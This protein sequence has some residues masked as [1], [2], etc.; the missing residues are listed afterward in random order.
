MVL[1]P[2]RLRQKQLKSEL[3]TGVQAPV[4]S[5]PK[6]GRKRGGKRA[7][8]TLKQTRHTRLLMEGVALVLAMGGMFAGYLAWRLS[9]GTVSIV[10]ATPLVED[11]L[12]RLVGGPTKIGT[13]RLGWDPVERD[14]VV[15]AG[16]ITAR[17]DKRTSPLRL[18]QV[19]MALDAPSLLA[20]RAVVKQARLS[21]VEAVLVI[22]QQGRTAFGF[23]TAQQVLALPRVLGQ[24]GALAHMI[25]ATRKA[26]DPTG[27]AGRVAQVVLRNAQLQVIDPDSGERL[28][29]QGAQAGLYRNEVGIITFHASG[30]VSNSPSSINIALAAP[31]DP[32]GTLSVIANVNQIR[33]AQIP[34]SLRQGQMEK[35]VSW[36]SPLGGRALG[37]LTPN[38]KVIDVAGRIEVGAGQ[39]AGFV[40]DRAKGQFSWQ[41][42]SGIIRLENAS[43]SGNHIRGEGLQAIVFPLDSASRRIDL[44]AKSFAIEDMTLGGLMGTQVKGRLN[45]SSQSRLQTAQLSAKSLGVSATDT[46]TLTLLDARLTLSSEGAYGQNERSTVDGL[47]AGG[48]VKGNVRAAGVALADRGGSLGSG[49][50]VALDFGKQGAG[51]GWQGSASL[52]NLNLVGRGASWPQT[53]VRGLSVRLDGLGIPSQT[54]FNLDVES[55]RTRQIVGRGL[56][57]SGSN[58]RVAVRSSRAGAWALENFSADA[59]GV[60]TPILG[61]VSGPLRASGTFSKLG[62]QDAEIQTSILSL[63]NPAQVPRP[64][65][66]TDV[67]FDGDIL[68]RKVTFREAQFRHRGIDVEGSGEVALAPRGS[69]KVYLDA[70]IDGEINVETLLSAWPRGF[71][72]ETR[73][74]IAQ[75]VR[76]GIATTDKLT[77]RVPPGL[78]HGQMGGPDMIA[79]DFDVREGTVQYLPGMTALTNVSG[80]ARLRGNSFRVDV[81]RGN[82]DGLVLNQGY[83]AIPQ[84]APKEALAVV[85]ATVTG[86]VARMASEADR[87]PLR[88]FSNVQFDP[89]RLAGEGSLDLDL[90]LPLSDRLKPDEV[91]VRARGHFEQASLKDAFAGLEA[92]DGAVDLD[93]AGQRVTVAGKARLAGNTFDFVWKN[94]IEPSNEKANLQEGSQLLA[95]GL[96]DLA[97]LNQM[98][99]DVS[100]YATGPVQLSVDVQSQSSK[101]V[102]A[103]VLADVQPASIQLQGSSWSKPAGEPG[104]AKARIVGQPG[105]GWQ[106]NGLEFETKGASIRGQMALSDQLDLKVADFPQIRIE[107]VADI[108]FKLSQEKGALDLAVI[109]EYLDLN[110]FR[111]RVDVTE[112]AANLL[113]QPMR[114]TAQIKR[115]ATGPI[116]SLADMEAT[117][118]RDEAGWRSMRIT[119]QAEAGPTEIEMKPQADGRR[120]IVGTLSDVGFF[121]RLMYPAAPLSGGTGV[122][123]GELPIVGAKS[124]GN[125]SLEVKNISFLQGNQIPIAFDLVRLPMSVSGGLLS[126][127]DGKADG[128]AYTVKA[129]GYVDFE[130]GQ[131]DLRGVATPGG[132]NRVLGEVPL[133]GGLLGG[134]K[135]EGLVGLTFSA[136]GSLANPK[137]RTNPISA[138]APG[139]LRKLFETQAPNEPPKA[140]QTP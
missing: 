39:V 11:A 80:R 12:A 128:A 96:V 117:I 32:Q 98:G 1:I 30:K 44:D 113:K 105:L 108:G 132:L 18:G 133:I 62:L 135:D 90:S 27:Q 34:R 104:S 7:K 88:I 106:V 120:T 78:L 85:Q 9:I 52:A 131:M 19:D 25:Q 87:E 89:A 121:A 118:V 68:S 47:L 112:H 129:E 61:M 125:L 37:H 54:V 86:S 8:R 4:S 73:N 130:A 59:L 35:L 99:I 41:S 22:D 42:K 33:I 20:G 82:L 3:D 64:F 46:R 56:G 127:R 119:G 92:T 16:Q 23:G 69:A 31:P 76:T 93:V 72:R 115:V 126:L 100:A 74:A 91:N 114:V 65:V 136:Q 122:I 116:S 26:L 109:G 10:I 2:I 6:A 102:Q 14:F 51:T 66:A 50:R 81:D 77:L 29:L 83:F 15:L 110:P 84:F 79:L 101:L 13:L 139:F 107:N 97:S 103:D 38:G 28:V 58:V 48:F 138:L 63:S 45:L 36:T 67:S 140:L 53:Q 137:L 49:D 17:T 21:G 94:Q 111:S 57:L 70:R 40:L 75:V 95:N 24:E 123:Q 124:E 5:S 55:L 134:G 43:V 60:V 71:L